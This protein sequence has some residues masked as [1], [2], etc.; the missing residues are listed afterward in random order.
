MNILLTFL[1]GLATTFSPCIFPMLPILIATNLSKSTSRLIGLI[2]G[3]VLSFGLVSVISVH[4]LGF[5]DVETAQKIAL[6]ISL[7]FGVVLLVD[8]L[9]YKFNI[10]SSAVI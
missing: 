2:V 10:L 6:Y 3:F 9:Y 8:W 7:L 1:E 5:F 4:I